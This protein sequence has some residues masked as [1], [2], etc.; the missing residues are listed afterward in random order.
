[1]ESHNNLKART[2]KHI[3]YKYVNL[4]HICF[5]AGQSCASSM[6]QCFHVCRYSKKSPACLCFLVDYRHGLLLLCCN[7]RDVLIRI[8]HALSP[9]LRHPCCLKPHFPC[10]LFSV[11]CCN[12]RDVLI[13]ISHAPSPLLR[14]PC[15][16]EPHFPCTLFSVTASVLFKIAFPMF[17]VSCSYQWPVSSSITLHLSH[18]IA[19]VLN[20]NLP[21]MFINPVLH[22]IITSTNQ[23]AHHKPDCPSCIA[24]HGRLVHRV[25]LAFCGLTY[26]REYSLLNKVPGLQCDILTV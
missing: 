6:Q 16:F 13:R 15:C 1:M 17:Y 21:F 9:L 18:N 3:H 4:H 23:P 10:T 11:L 12:M 22:L 14:H 26:F 24:G 19:L 25:L 7:M 2:V 8:S 5:D 20:S